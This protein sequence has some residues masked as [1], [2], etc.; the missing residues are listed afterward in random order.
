[1]CGTSDYDH[2][3]QASFEKIHDELADQKITRPMS[4]SAY[5]PDVYGDHLSHRTNA[6]TNESIGHVQSDRVRTVR[7]DEYR[8][9]CWAHFILCTIPT[10][11]QIEDHDGQAVALSSSSPPS[12][13]RFARERNLIYIPGVSPLCNNLSDYFSKLSY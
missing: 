5:L 8:E 3:Q 7:A 1:M 11:F 6:Q 2:A 13:H 10:I 4:L 12:S 9:G